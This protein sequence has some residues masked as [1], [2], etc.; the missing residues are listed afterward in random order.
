MDLFQKDGSFST[1]WKTWGSFLHFRGQGILFLDGQDGTNRNRWKMWCLY[2]KLNLLDFCKFAFRS[3][4]RLKFWCGKLSSRLITTL[5]SC[6]AWFLTKDN[7]LN[8]LWV[9]YTW[10]CFSMLRPLTRKTC[11]TLSTSTWRR[12]PPRRILLSMVTTKQLFNN[13]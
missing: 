4:K 8:K 11:V 6:R 13:A 5:Q 2:Q 9:H 7:W 10:N 12:L 1:R 3:W